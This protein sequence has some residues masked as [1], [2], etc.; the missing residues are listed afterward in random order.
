MQERFPLGPADRVAQKTPYGFDVSAWEFFWPLIAGASLV[1]ARPGG[2]ADPAYLARLLHDE[3]VTVTHFV[4][5]VLGMFLRHPAAARCTALRYVFASGEALPVATMRT[6]YEV[7]GTGTELHNLYG[8]TEAA[9]DVTHW[10][11]RPDWDEP[12]VPIG[13]PVAHTRIHLLDEDLRPVPPGTPGEIVIGGRQVALGYH[14]RPE[15]N[16]ERFIASPFPDDDPS[17]RLYRTG[18][19]GLLAEDGE[20]RYLGRIDNQFKLRG[21][22]IEPEEIEAALTDVPAVAEARVLPV[23]DESSGEQALA[24]VCVAA[25]SGREPDVSALRRAL[26]ETL[27]AYLVP[28][29]YRFVDRLPLTTNGKL[30]RQAATRLFDTP[31]ATAATATAAAPAAP[32]AG[33]AA[34]AAPAADPAPAPAPVPVAVPGVDAEVRRAVADIL[35]VEELD[36]DADLFDLGATSFTMIRIAQEIERLTGTALPVE[37]LISKPTLDALTAL[38]APAPPA[39]APAP[40]AGGPVT[41]ETVART[42]AGILGVDQVGPDDDLFDLG[43]TS[44]TMIRLAQEIETVS[45]GAQVPVEVLIQSPTPRS[46]A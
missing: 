25:H 7:L 39:A 22:R 5:S 1:V 40:A 42:A 36:G 3:Q 14:R 26:G 27:P 45:G 10:A 41:A 4:P 43:A 6:F 24:A 12:T 37:A 8:P 13:R 46:I 31:P 38:T 44:F 16:A 19:L 2:H 29:R 32:A 30:D 17:P 21:L 33:A 18:D 23:H 15:L 34:P 9:I 11:C 28:S 20:I 35:G